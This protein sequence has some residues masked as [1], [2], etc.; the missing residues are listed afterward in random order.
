MRSEDH[1]SVRST[2]STGSKVHMLSS[3]T[4]LKTRPHIFCCCS[5]CFSANVRKKLC[6]SKLHST[7]VPAAPQTQKCAEAGPSFQCQTARQ[8]TN[9]LMREMCQVQQS[10]TLL[11]K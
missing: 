5:Q 7:A 11:L 6:F 8:G 9:L 4:A 10:C 3:R 2:G 1:T